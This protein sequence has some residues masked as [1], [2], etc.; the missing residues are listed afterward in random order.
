MRKAARGRPL[1]QS[2]K[3]FYKLI[4]K[5]RFRVEQCFGTMK[6][7]FGLHRARYFGRAKTHAQMAMAAIGQNLIKAANKITLDL[8][9][10]A[11]A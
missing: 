9:T 10:L 11:I 2:E 7:L 8:Q 5:R 4:S 1:R 6:R 3:R